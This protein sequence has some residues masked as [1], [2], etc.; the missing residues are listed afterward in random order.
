M[1]YI[2]VPPLRPVVDASGILTGEP[3]LA[4]SQWSAIAGGAMWLRGKG[5]VLVPMFSP[6]GEAKTASELVFRFRVK[7]RSSAVQRIWTVL[8]DLDPGVGEPSLCHVFVKAPATTGTAVH[9][10][11]SAAPTGTD[12]RLPTEITVVEDLSSKSSTEGEIT[13]GIQFLTNVDAGTMITTAR[14]VGI[15]CREQDRAVLV[16]DANDQAVRLETVRS[17]EPIARVSNVGPWGALQTLRASDPR[18]VGIFHFAN[19]DGI[20]HT[21]TTPTN[22]LSIAAKIQ[23]QLVTRST[24]KTAVKWAAYARSTTGVTVS[25]AL[26]TSSGASDSVSFTSTTA[27][28]SA[29]RS[30]N[31]NAD[32]LSQADFLRD[33][34]LT[35]TLAGGG[36]GAIQFYSFS[37]WTEDVT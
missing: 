17:G 30:I 28:W 34:A 8:V 20:S 21:S 13:V 24:T 9:A 35:I 29:A 7:P 32:D 16:D 5:A 31:I 36:T 11:A 27:A 3:V 22:L 23:A 18:R 14:V 19:P 37:M 1:T 2:P 15:A 26:S 33:D 10:L 4:P 25:V 6:G 12:A